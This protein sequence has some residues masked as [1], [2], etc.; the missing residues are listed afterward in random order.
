[1]QLATK[2]IAIEGDD[3]SGKSTASAYMIELLKSKGYRVLHAG[4]A[5]LPAYAKQLRELI[6][7]PYLVGVSKNASALMFTSYLLN[8]YEDLIY[9][10][11]GQYDFIVIDRTYL[12]TLVYQNGSELL[13]L[14]VPSLPKHMTV[15]ALVYL[16]VNPGVGIER[17]KSREGGLDEFE[18]SFTGV[19]LQKRHTLYRHYFDTLP[20]ERK[21]HVDANG[22]LEHSKERIKYITE[23]IIS[24]YK[25]NQEPLKT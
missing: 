10:N 19:M 4:P 12:S 16:E 21:Y 18:K 8:I 15:D 13:Q 23:R 6:V 9:P 17:I 5:N 11:L 1:M 25:T 22:T 24:D 2:I 14:L 20:I 7:G 3:G